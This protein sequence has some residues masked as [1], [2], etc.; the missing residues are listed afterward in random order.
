MFQ[1]IS[2]KRVSA[3][4]LVAALS[5]LLTGCFVTPGKFVSELVLKTDNSFSFTYKGEIFFLGLSQLAMMGASNQ[6]FIAEGCYD[7]DNWED[8]ECT[9]A[10]LAEQRAEWDAGAADRER[11]QKEKAK[12]MAAI[13]GGIDPSDPDA[14]NELARKL[15]RQRGWNTVEYVA[16][17]LFK[18]EYAISGQL[19]H[20]IV[21][22]VIEGVPVPSPFVQVVLRDNNQ[23]RINAAGFGNEDKGSGNSGMLTGMAAGMGTLMSQ[24]SAEEGSN[25]NEGNPFTNL[26]VMDGTFTITTNGQVLANNT[27]EGPAETAIGKMLS[28][29]VDRNTKS[30]PTALI[31]LAE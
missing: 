1:Q 14:G 30:A 22:P 6:E 21:F 25:D 31:K 2:G 5:L 16:N 18:V 10:E 29:K 24:R 13:L 3:T 27:D 15:Q 8:R 7:D 9:E 20:D 12:E 23:V 19:S 26:P 4:A 17:G 11:E 28:W